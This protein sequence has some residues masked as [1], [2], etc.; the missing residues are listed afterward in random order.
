LWTGEETEES[1]GESRPPA[2]DAR[3]EVICDRCFESLEHGE[4]GQYK[5]PLEPRSAAT[6]VVGDELVGGFVQENFGNTPEVFY[7]KKAMAARAKE[8]GLMPFVRH[9]DGDKH[10]SRWV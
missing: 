1:G 4:H 3:R 5:C 8:L 10:V 7:S 9:V 2:E 6:N